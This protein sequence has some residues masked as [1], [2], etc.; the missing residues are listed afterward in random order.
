VWIPEGTFK[1]PGHLILNNITF[2]GAGMWR[3]TV[4]GAALHAGGTLSLDSP[5]YE[6]MNGGVFPAGLEPRKRAMTLETLL[7]MS[8]GYWCD[9]TDPKAPGNE[10]TM[11]DQDAQP[12]YLKYTLD[13]PMATDPGENAVYC[14]INPNLALGLVGRATGESPLYSFDR[15]VGGPLQIRRY[16]W[17]YDPVGHPYGGG[18]AQFLPRDFM[19]FGQLMLDGGVWHG[20]RILSADF[21]K[22]ASSPMYQLGSMKY[23]YAWWSM[24]YPHKNRTVHAFAALGNGGQN[25]IVVPDLDLVVAVYASNYGDRVMMDIQ[26]DL[27]PKQIL[28]A[29]KDARPKP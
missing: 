9:D 19:K 25:V 12:D 2:K 10:E 28:S 6:V 15:L 3:S 14:S 13:L 4:V 7:T 26:N 5:V 22:R 20:K 24:D 17:P 23:G 21:V 11:L 29:V 16:A 1:I 8:S 18:G 27:V